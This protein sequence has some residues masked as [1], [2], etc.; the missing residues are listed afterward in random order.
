LLGC[1]RQVTPPHWLVNW[2]LIA[3]V[4]KR[5][6]KQSLHNQAFKRHRKRQFQVRPQQ[7]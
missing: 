3:E 2:L 6:Y 7:L 5:W 4:V 1:F